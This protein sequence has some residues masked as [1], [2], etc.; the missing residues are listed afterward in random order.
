MGSAPLPLAPPSRTLPPCHPSPRPAPAHGRP[1]PPSAAW[2]HATGYKFTEV[3]NQTS[4]FLQGPE[5]ERDSERGLVRALRDEQHTRVRLLNYDKAGEPFFNTVECFP[6]RD[7][8]GNLTHFCGV[9]A[10]EPAGPG[11]LRRTTPPPLLQ[12]PPV[13]SCLESEEGI[14]R[15]STREAPVRR[16]KRQRGHQVRLAEALNNTSDAVVMTQPHHP[17]AITH[18]NQPWCDMCG[19]TQEE[20]EGLPNSILQGP[21]TDQALLQDLMLSVQRG[22]PTSAT[23]VNYKKDGKR[24][25][26]QVSVTPVYNDEDELEQFMAM[27]HE[28]DGV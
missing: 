6:L 1:R 3:A 11:Y 8:E 27:L 4:A 26:N 5:T 16:P 13:T 17:Y 15:R 24:F 14:S 19:Y 2:H 7:T 21:E 25:V 18:V 23:L 12:Q 28:V 22:E 9:L 10:C 20:V